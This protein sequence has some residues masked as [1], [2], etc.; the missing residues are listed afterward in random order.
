M[1]YSNISDYGVIGN[2]ET[3]A[4]VGQAGSIDWYCHPYLDSPSV[5]AAILDDERGGRWSIA[6]AAPYQSRQRY[7]EHTN[8]L[9]T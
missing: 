5:F 3:V 2:L 1:G 8:I 9:I 4:L 6:P 7:F